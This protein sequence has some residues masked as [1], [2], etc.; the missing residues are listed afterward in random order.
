MSH[1]VAGDNVTPGAESL[2][3]DWGWRWRL[4]P[5]RGPLGV[6][7]KMCFYILGADT[8]NGDELGG[9]ENRGGLQEGGEQ[10]FH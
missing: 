1:L 8:R 4:V 6:L 7:G 9:G 5:N 2:K 10:V 3:A